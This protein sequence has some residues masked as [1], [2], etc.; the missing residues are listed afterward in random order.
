MCCSMTGGTQRD[1]V[2]LGILAQLTA[3]LLVMNFKILQIA[4]RLTS[5]TIPLQDFAA[6]LLVGLAR[7]PQP[8]MFWPDSIHA[9]W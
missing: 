8:R 4:A 2:V 7:K 1:Q 6:E 3:E 9:V 5:P